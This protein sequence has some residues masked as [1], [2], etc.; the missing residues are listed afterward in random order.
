[1]KWKIDDVPVFVAVVEQNGVSAAAKYLNMPKSSV[2]IGLS[3][4]ESGLGV[5]L[6]ERNSRNLRITPEGE[7][8]YRRAQLIV[9]QVQEA[10]AAVSGLSAAPRGRLTVAMPAAF[11]QEVLAPHVA[12]FC[13]LHPNLE[14]ELMVSPQGLRMVQDQADL[15][16]IDGPLPDTTLV[17][18]SLGTGPLI[19]VA[20]PSVAMALPTD[21]TADQIAGYVEICE[22]RHGRSRFPVELGG[23]S[24][25]IDLLH[26]ISHVNDPITVREAV[27]NGA[28]VAPLPRRY[29]DRLLRNGSLVE[30][31]ENL[32]CL[33]NAPGLTAVCTAQ[34]AMSPRVRSFLGFVAPL[35]DGL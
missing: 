28:G 23:R 29:C 31:F 20:A 14:L 5:R 17:S 18:R 15:A 1:M 2:S 10:D 27:R 7:N 3:R 25:H 11:A 30:V 32:R 8:F 13:K 35:C 33:S 4:L 21:V 34:Q 9:E 22:T 12:Q 24:C 6:I 19:W 26:G 16:I